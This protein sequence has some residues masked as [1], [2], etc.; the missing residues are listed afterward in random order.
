MEVPM[1]VDKGGVRVCWRNGAAVGSAR[2]LRIPVVAVA[3]GV[4]GRQL[5]PVGLH[6]VL[7]GGS[8]VQTDGISERSG[9]QL[10][11]V[12]PPC[13]APPLGGFVDPA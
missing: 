5:A 6:G 7:P 1:T 9:I 8:R 10:T 3:H 4:R 11:A 12:R 2:V 13:K